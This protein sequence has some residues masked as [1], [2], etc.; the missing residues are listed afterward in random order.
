MFEQGDS[1]TI[2]GG[3]FFCPRH[4][5]YIDVPD[6]GPFIVDRVYR[7]SETDPYHWRLSASSDIPRGPDHTTRVDAIITAFEL[8]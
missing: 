7:T 2:K 5:G 4:G 6:K 1:V 3:R 8:T